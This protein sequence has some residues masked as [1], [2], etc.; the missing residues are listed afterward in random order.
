MSGGRSKHLFARLF[1]CEE[2]DNDRP[3]HVA[4]VELL[5]VSEWRCWKIVSVTQSVNRV[6]SVISGYDR[7]VCC[8]FVVGEV[9][10]MW[11][12]IRGRVEVAILSTDDTAL[13]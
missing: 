12:S 9:R 11:Y 2:G 13:S 8:T 1:D 3:C 7:R 4:H 6:D 10:V 5:V